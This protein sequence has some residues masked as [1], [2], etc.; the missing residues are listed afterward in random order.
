MN[1][2]QKAVLT[3]IVIAIV[4]VFYSIYTIVDALMKGQ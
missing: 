4:G 3:I 1:K 2:N